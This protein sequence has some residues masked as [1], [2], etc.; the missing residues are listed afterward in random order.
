[1]RK[2]FIFFSVFMLLG[3]TATAVAASSVSVQAT[4]AKSKC[5]NNQERLIQALKD[6]QGCFSDA[7]AT[8]CSSKNC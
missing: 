2:I 1:M 4:I 3:I 5:Y 8:I 6:L 7:L